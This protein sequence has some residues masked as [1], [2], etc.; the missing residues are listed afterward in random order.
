MIY[1]RL[2]VARDLL[3]DDGVI[4]ISIDDNEVENLKKVCNE[5]FGT[6]NFF[7]QTIIRSN[8]RGQTY[9]QI[10]R[11]HEYLL[12][13]TKSD[14][15]ELFELEKDLDNSDLNLTDDI[16]CFNI[17]ELRNRNPKF[18]RHNRPGLFFPIYINTNIVDKDGFHPVSLTASEEYSVELLPYNSEGRESC[19]RW[20][21]PKCNDNISSNTLRSNL[22][23]KPKN[24][25]GYNI[26]P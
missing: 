11:T 4:F 16:S 10:A 21:K 2:K 14:L 18:G 15:T 12:I 3:A 1:P 5:I 22:I 26:Y 9:K 7:S 8:S 24:G 6:N 20:G 23:A 25:G 13:F 19:W 17:R